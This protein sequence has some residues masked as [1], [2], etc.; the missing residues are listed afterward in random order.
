MLILAPAE[1]LFR[2]TLLLPP[3]VP[4]TERWDVERLPLGSEIERRT[5]FQRVARTASAGGMLTNMATRHKELRFLGP[6]VAPDAPVPPALELYGKLMQR[7]PGT[8]IVDDSALMAR[9]RVVKEPREL[10]QIRRAMDATR[11]GHLAAMRQVRSGWT[12]RRLKDL[13]ESEFRAGGGQGLA[14]ES[15]VAAG[16]NAASLHYTGGEGPIQ[17][18]A[19]ILIDAGASVGGYACDVTRTFPVDGRFTPRQREVYELVLR[20]QEAAV[21]KLRA[22]AYFEDL[23]EAAREV[24]RRAGRLDDFYHGLGHFVGLHV[25]DAGDYSQ[26]LPAAAVITI[27]PGLYVQSENWG[28]RIEDQ[29]LI[30]ATGSERMSVDIPRT[31]AEIESFMAQGRT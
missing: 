1:R 22:G 18:G 24:F 5:G 29:Y 17:R 27:E 8:R 9:M 11:R 26:P 3:R 16:R 20:A 7:V 30:T 31:V 4:E 12:E 13:L 23:S 2:E 6:I 21:A 25:H 10:E 19:L 14:Y 28:I 15:I